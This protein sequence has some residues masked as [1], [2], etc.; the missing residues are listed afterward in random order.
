MPRTSDS[1][2]DPIYFVIDRSGRA[3]GCAGNGVCYGFDPDGNR[4]WEFPF[5][6]GNSEGIGANLIIPANG[7]IIIC[8]NDGVVRAI[9]SGKETTKLVAD[10][11]MVWAPN[12]TDSDSQVSIKL[13]STGRNLRW[14]IGGLLPYWIRVN[15]FTSYTT[16]T[17]ITFRLINMWFPFDRET[18]VP[19]IADNLDPA[20]GT[21]DI[22]FAA[23]RG[24]LFLPMA[25]R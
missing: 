4:L 15:S 10:K 17:I 3:Y 1:D 20:N 21:V 16:P 6:Y 25:I 23:L 18:V 2:E 8:G 12:H 11:T 14:S 13:T 5:N 22:H 19:I 7:T 24:Q 9:S